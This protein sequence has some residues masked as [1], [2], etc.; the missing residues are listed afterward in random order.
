M[1]TVLLTLAILLLSS[2]VIPG[3]TEKCWNLHGHCRDTCSRNEKVYVF[4]LSGKLCCVKPK[5]QP[6]TSPRLIN[7]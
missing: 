5:F 6:N 3:S 2:Q 7:A 1:K 4:C